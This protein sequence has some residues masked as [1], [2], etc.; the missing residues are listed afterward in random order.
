MADIKWIKLTTDMFDDEKIDFIISLPEGDSLV[1]V[2]IRLLAMAGKNN[3]GGFIFLTE[4]IPYSEDM[5][6]HKFKKPLNVIKLAIKTFKELNMIEFDESGRL[7]I[8]NWSKHQNI[9]GLDKVREQNRLRKKVERERKKLGCH[10]T[11]TRDIRDEVA[12]SHAIEQEQELDTY[13]SSDSREK[14]ISVYQNEIGII[15]PI[16]YEMIIDWIDTY[17][18]DWIIEAIKVAVFNNARK[19]SYVGAVLSKW[20]ING[21]KTNSDIKKK[22]Q[23]RKS[24]GDQDMEKL[25]E[26]LL[27]RDRNNVTKSNEDVSSQLSRL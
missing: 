8:T 15:S 19:Q 24:K 9:E 12:P 25:E 5:L 17:P 13:S 7:I 20:K 2:W 4:N 11:V 3:A 22:N 21:F 27:G 16:A 10:V 18:A 1:V 6:S 14:I 26:L 23:P